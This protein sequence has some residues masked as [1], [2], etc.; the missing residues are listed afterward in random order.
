MRSR[1]ILA[2][3]VFLATGVLLTFVQLKLENPLLVLER[4]VPGGGW[5]ELFIAAAYGGTVAW[6]MYDPAKSARWRQ[7]TWLTFSIVF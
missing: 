7:V 3:S 6:F 4:F 2:V 5:I 1:T